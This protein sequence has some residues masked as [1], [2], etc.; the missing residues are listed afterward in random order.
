MT[1]L[2][3]LELSHSAWAALAPLRLVA[4]AVDHTL[5]G[6][7]YQADTGLSVSTLQKDDSGQVSA[8]ITLGNEFG[9][10]DARFALLR[11]SR[12]RPVVTLRWYVDEALDTGP[13]VLQL[14]DPEAQGA[15]IV[16]ELRNENDE[17]MPAHRLTFTLENTPTLRGLT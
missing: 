17:D 4:D 12:E 8:Q 10:H 2:A 13:V 11:G 15:G 6:I 7:D 5:G 1:V 14:H 3:T 16:A 9:R